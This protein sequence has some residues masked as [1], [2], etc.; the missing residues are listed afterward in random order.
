MAKRMTNAQLVDENIRLR[1]Q[2]DVLEGKVASRDTLIRDLDEQIRRL[3]LRYDALS[4]Q[5]SAPSAVPAWRAAAEH[6]RA[7]SKAYFKAN[8]SAKS[9]TD[10][11]LRDFETSFDVRV[12]GMQYEERQHEAA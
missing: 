8:P 2:C 5:R 7:M 12:A 10:E 3:N 4:V 6:R 9:V 11:Q 1:A